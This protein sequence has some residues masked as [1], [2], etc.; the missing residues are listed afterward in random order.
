MRVIKREKE[1]DNIIS[2]LLTGIKITD[3][4]KT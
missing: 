4:L 1:D 3:H 2:V